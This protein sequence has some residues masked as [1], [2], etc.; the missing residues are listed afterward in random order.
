MGIHCP[1][2]DYLLARDRPRI[3]LSFAELEAL[4]GPP[5]DEAACR[6]R[7]WVAIGETACP[8]CPDEAWGHAGYRAD[9]PDFATQTVTY[10]RIPGGG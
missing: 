4:A 7:W 5:P 2:V 1:L 9:P 10:R 3:A 8:Y 6:A